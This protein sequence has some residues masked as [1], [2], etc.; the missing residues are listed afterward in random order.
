MKHYGDITQLSGYTLPPVDIITGG[1][2][3]QDLS[4][5]GERR[6]LTGERSGLFMQQIRIVK[7]MREHDKSGSDNYFRLYPRPRYVVWEN[8]QGA[9]T[10]PGK[11]K[12]G[13]DFQAVLT[14]FVRIACSNAPDVPMPERGGWNRAGC[15]YGVGD[16]GVP[17]SLAWRVTDAQF[18]GAEQRRKRVCVLVDLSG[19]TAPELLFDV[20][21]QRTPA[22]GHAGGC[23]RHSGKKSRYE[24]H[25]FPESV[26]GDIKKS[27]TE[28][29]ATS[30]GAYRGI[31]GTGGSIDKKGVLNDSKRHMYFSSQQFGAY[32]ISNKSS[33]LQ[34]RDYK[35][36]ADLIV[37]NG[38]IVRRTTPLE[39]ERLQG[40]PDNWTNIGE[41]VDKKRKKHNKSSDADRFKAL[42]NSIALHF[43]QWLAIKICAQYE[44]TPTIGSLFDGIGGFPLVFQRAGADPVWASEIEEF[45]IAVTK[46][47]FGEG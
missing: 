27:G 37:E 33:C 41:W 23:A 5:A 4:T 10:S 3:C 17:F 29:E 25:A 11:D 39:A 8:V 34:A 15:L 30:A 20:K 12:N 44:A 14:H 7:E 18:W 9:L 24:V 16:G 38:V 43:W 31:N 36:P 19:V 47:H 22:N 40:Y 28:G 2:P 6:G 1:S 35:S 21:Y 32:K 45:C 13:R 42:G 26:Q 46:K